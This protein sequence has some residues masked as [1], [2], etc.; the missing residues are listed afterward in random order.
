M[1][2]EFPKIDL[3]PVPDYST[4][5][6][7]EQLYNLKTEIDLRQEY[8]TAIR[9]AYRDQGEGVYEG[10]HF[11]VKVVPLKP[12]K[13]LDMKRI[14]E[15]MS[16]EDIERFSVEKERRPLVLVRPTEALKEAGRIIAEQHAPGAK[17]RFLNK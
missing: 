8:R 11:R 2:I 7:P 1:A 9:D 4:M 16:H 13:K 5:D 6:Q 10:K 12:T 14:K 3:P 15:A 17:P